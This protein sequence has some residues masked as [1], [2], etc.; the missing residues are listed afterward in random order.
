M[1]EHQG[2]SEVFADILRVLERIEEKLGNQDRRLTKLEDR[3]EP[4]GNG[5]MQESP[6][7]E[8]A[9]NPP[10]S[11]QHYP[12]PAHPHADADEIKRR[13]TWE[14]STLGGDS[15]QENAKRKLPYGN[16][17]IQDHANRYVDPKGR[18]LLQQYL[19][20][21]WKIPED[22]RFP[23]AFSRHAILRTGTAWVHHAATAPS[24]SLSGEK[25]LQA[26]RAFDRGL[27]SHGGND[28]LV[29]DYDPSNNAR[30]YRVG[31]D[32]IGD[33]LSVE[34]GYEDAPWSRLM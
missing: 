16:W 23:L 26:M 24:F 29:V 31:E 17:S 2:S 5:S 34:T 21:C 22:H 8:R 18:L 28:F 27:K 12:L 9:L 19:G 6:R 1:T 14:A 30:L 4:N 10:P 33:E 11:T 25:H 3:N 15:D 13:T 7:T 32:A 20:D